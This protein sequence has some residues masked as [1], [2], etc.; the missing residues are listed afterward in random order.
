LE[1]ASHESKNERGRLG[2]IFFAVVDIPGFDPLEVDVFDTSAETAAAAIFDTLTTLD[3]K[4]A[5]RPKL[6]L[7]WTHSDD[8]K[9]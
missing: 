5:A 8:Y 4:A 3:D 1:G 6:A 7:S 2:P 9:T